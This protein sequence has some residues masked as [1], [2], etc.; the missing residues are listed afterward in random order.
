[1][2]C[3]CAGVLATDRY[4]SSPPLDCVNPETSLS[5][6]LDRPRVL[7]GGTACDQLGPAIGAAGNRDADDVV[8]GAPPTMPLL[9]AVVPWAAPLLP[10]PPLPASHMD[11][12]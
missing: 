2:L 1:M 11:A 3:C 7:K 12:G 6:L 9:L 4:S 10:L 8:S 5:M